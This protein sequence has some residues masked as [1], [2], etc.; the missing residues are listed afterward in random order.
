MLNRRNDFRL[1]EGCAAYIPFI[2]KIDTADLGYYMLMHALEFGTNEE[3]P[4]GENNTLELE[5]E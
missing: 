3:Y 2:T 5:N 1:R 4:R